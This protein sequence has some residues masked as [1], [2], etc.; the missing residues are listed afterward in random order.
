MKTLHLI[1]GAAAGVTIALSLIGY[2]Q[3]IV[4]G[5]EVVALISGAVAGL[6]LIDH[7]ERK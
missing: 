7:I 3:N 6:I 1:T 5:A 2:V 4:G